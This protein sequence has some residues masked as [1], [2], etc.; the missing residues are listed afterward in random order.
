MPRLRATQTESIDSD[1]VRINDDES[2]DTDDSIDIDDVDF[3]DA[4]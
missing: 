4:D 1:D 3:D 2:D